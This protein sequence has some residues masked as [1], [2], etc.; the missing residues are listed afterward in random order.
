MSAN[1]V[2]VLSDRHRSLRADMTGSGLATQIISDLRPICNFI[3]ICT[4]EL[5][6]GRILWILLILS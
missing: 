2:H 1:Y 6:L 5:Y 4:A 3:S